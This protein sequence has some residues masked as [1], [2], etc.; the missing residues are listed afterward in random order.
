MAAAS[1]RSL[2]SSLGLVLV[3]GHQLSGA[4]GHLRLAAGEDARQLLQQLDAPAIVCEGTAA[5]DGVDARVAADLLL[6]E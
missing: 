2:R 4:S 3:G 6:S 1:R 5:H